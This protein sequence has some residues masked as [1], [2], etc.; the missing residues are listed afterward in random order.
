VVL[1][2]DGVQDDGF[3]DDDDEQLN[4]LLTSLTSG[5]EGVFTSP[6]RIFP[7]AYGEGADFAT[8]RRIGE[9]TNAAVY[10]ASNPNTIQQVF[11]AVVSNF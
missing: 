5:T 8:L 2:T 9:A 1:L 6:V 3:A 4:E 11:T 7:I 10:D